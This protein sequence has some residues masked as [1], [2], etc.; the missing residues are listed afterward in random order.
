MAKFI[1]AHD[2]HD[3]A[4]KFPEEDFINRNSVYGVMAQNGCVLM[5]Q[6]SKSGRW[7]LP[8]GGVESGESELEALMRE[9]L[10]ETGLHIPSDIGFIK[11]FIEYCYDLPTKQAWKSER[12][13]FK[14]TYFSGALLSDG[15]NDDV[16]KAEFI[17]PTIFREL[18]TT[19]TIKEVLAPDSAE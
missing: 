7:E 8:G 17:N 16:S 9:V 14:V 1:T 13:F 6:D 10:E 19:K 11:S 18:R 15:N 12:K 3:K 4:Y 2:Y 5:V